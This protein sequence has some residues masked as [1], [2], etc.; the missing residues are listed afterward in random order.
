MAAEIRIARQ[1]VA[2]IGNRFGQHIG[3]GAHGPCVERQIALRHAGLTVEAIG[4]PGNGR[5]K[6]HGKPVIELRV[7]TL[8]AN[9]Q[10]VIVKRLHPR[11]P[12]VAQ[13]EPRQITRTGGKILA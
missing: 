2:A 3:P 4:L 8:D 6:R 10:R 11:K 13:I 12:E 7:Q 5:D 1:H 9:A